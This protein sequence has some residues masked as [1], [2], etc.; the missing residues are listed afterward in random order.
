VSPH[1]VFSAAIVAI[2]VGPIFP[3]AA[4]LFYYDQRIRREGFDIEWMMSAA[5]MNAPVAGAESIA[6]EEPEE[7]PA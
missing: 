2:L 6:A 5:G 4:T 1:D 3:I 7:R